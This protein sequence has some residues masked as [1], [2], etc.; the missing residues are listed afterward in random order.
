ME[1]L[2]RESPNYQGVCSPIV[3]ASC[4]VDVTL[5][6]LLSKKKANLLAPYPCYK[7][8]D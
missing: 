6:H 1:A 8:D 7:L 2:N 3:G 4:P 5:S